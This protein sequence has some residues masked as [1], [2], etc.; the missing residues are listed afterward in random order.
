M[1]YFAIDFNDEM[2]DLCDCGDI[3]AAE[4][5]ANDLGIDAWAIFPE[6]TVREWQKL[7]N[8]NLNREVT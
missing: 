8:R 4:E 1:K 3:A 5:S 2:Y 6:T 7:L